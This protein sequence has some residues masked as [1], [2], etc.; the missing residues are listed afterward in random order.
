M[1]AGTTADDSV[2]TENAR[3]K[4]RITELEEL[5]RVR[6]EQ[7][8]E[9]KDHAKNLCDLYKNLNIIKKDRIEIERLSELVENGNKLERDCM[10]DH[11]LGD[12]AA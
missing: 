1:S 12:A 8:K 11:K 6:K 7:V 9:C 2:L 3:L 4:Q 10:R 5:V